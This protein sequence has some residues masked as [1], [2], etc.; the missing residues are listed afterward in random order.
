MISHGRGSALLWKTTF[1]HTRHA[2]ETSR[3]IANKVHFS[4]YQ[5]R[6]LLDTGRPP[7]TRLWVTQSQNEFIAD[8]QEAIRC[9]KEQLAKA[10]LRQKRF[11][12]RHRVETSFDVSD[13]VYVR[14]NLLNKTISTPD[15]DISQDP[16]KNK[17]LPRWIE[18]FP[19]AKRIGS[20]AYKLVLPA[21]LRSHDVFNVDQL[22]LS[23]GCPPEFVGRPI[24]RAA[25]VIYDDEGHRIYVVAAL[26]QKRRYRGRVQYLVKWADLPDSENSWE[27]IGNISHVAHWS[28]LLED[29]QQRQTTTA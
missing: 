4:R 12:D 10:Q 16:N 15:Y 25:P 17:L 24:R 11:Y 7:L 14:A 27:N 8:R 23:V 22:K 1:V 28:S 2:R 29:F 21:V 6:M 19:I 9:A 18:P 20:N 5:F 3:A 13:F 26:L